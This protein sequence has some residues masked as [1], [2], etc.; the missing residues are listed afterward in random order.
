MSSPAGQVDARRSE[1]LDALSQ[2]GREHSTATILFH[3]A[4]SEQLGL[5]VTDMK[6][7]DYLARLGPLTAGELGE[8]TGLATASVTGLIDRLEAKGFVRRVRDTKDRRRVIVEPNLEAEAGVLRLFQ[9]F[10]EF[11]M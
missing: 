9:S 1:L 3:S 4:I 7:L 11:L 6:T 2:A 8:R 5:G 10:G